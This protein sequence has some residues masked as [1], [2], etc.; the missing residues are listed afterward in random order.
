[1]KHFSVLS[2]SRLALFIGWLLAGLGPARAQAPGW[3]QL[4][5]PLS[6]ATGSTFIIASAPAQ[7][8]SG[9]IYI[10]GLTRNT[11]TF[12]STSFNLA[13]TDT[14]VAKWSPTAGFV[15]VVRC[16]GGAG[17]SDID[18]SFIRPTSLAVLGNSL[19]IGGLYSGAT[20]AFGPTVLPN[21]GST[22]YTTNSFVAKITDTGASASFAWA[23]RL[24][25]APTTA[26][27]IFDLH[28]LGASSSGVYAAGNFAGATFAVGGT[29]LTNAGSAGLP[30]VYL[31]KLTDAGT[32]G[33]VTWAKRAGGIGNDQAAALAVRGNTVY[34]TGFTNSPTA[35]FDNASAPGIGAFNLNTFVA[36]L[37]DSGSAGTFDWVTRAGS[38]ALS[39]VR[40]NALAL[41]GANVYIAGIYSGDA[42]FGGSSLPTVPFTGGDLNLFVAKLT[43]AG[44]SGS[45]QWGLAAGSAKADLVGG[46]AVSGNNVYVGGRF[47]GPAA[48]FGATV[49]TNPNQSVTVASAV[50]LAKCTD[51]GTS[52]AWA[53]AQQGGGVNGNAT[54]CQDE[55]TGVLLGTGRGY[56]LGTL[57]GLGNSSTPPTTVATFGSQVQTVPG[58]THPF[59]ATWTDNGL[60]AAAPAAARP[61][62]GLWPNPAHGTATVRLPAGVETEPLL[63]LDGLGRTVRRFATPARGATDAL[64]DLRGLPAG[65]YVLRGAGR[66]QH[67]AVE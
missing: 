22:Y 21:G 26:A 33:S 46:L 32:S 58:N 51:A 17:S 11:S 4:A 65:P 34:L 43:D 37:T 3:S 49:L 23:T 60:L 12:G 9:N 45:F 18:N 13:Q 31:A 35:S 36:R 5:L 25:F 42:T 41:S 48:T 47:T 39:I 27:T 44:S 57:L 40:P 15:W 67:L 56:L 53:W 61:V 54:I 28:T 20:A 50:Y 64:L 8:A 66:A 19:Y 62:L 29:T 7:D 63:L 24:S 59:I 10:V 1:M 2:A 38:T 30:D 55:A 52:G 6:S 14:Y 16:G